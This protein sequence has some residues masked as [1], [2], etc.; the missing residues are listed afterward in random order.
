LLYLRMNAVSCCCRCPRRSQ[1]LPLQ[2]KDA[3]VSIASDVHA[4]LL[5]RWKVDWDATGSIG[6][7]LARLGKR[8]VPPH[9]V[10]VYPWRPWVKPTVWDAL[11][12][13]PVTDTRQAVPP[14]GRGGHPAVH[15]RGPRER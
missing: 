2:N 7:R 3:F 4:R 10:R 8:P 13:A 1:V 5:Q 12:A 9:A 6:E 11:A 15:Y 14:A